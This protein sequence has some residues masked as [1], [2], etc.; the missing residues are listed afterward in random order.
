MA[1]LN[2]PDTTGYLLKLLSPA[3]FICFGQVNKQTNHL[4][5]NS[6][7]YQELCRLKFDKKV[8]KFGSYQIIKRYYAHDM[9]NVIAHYHFDCYHA[10][11]LAAKHGYLN[12]LRFIHETTR[13]HFPLAHYGLQNKNLI[14]NAIDIAIA[15]KHFHILKWFEHTGIITNH[16]LFLLSDIEYAATIGDLSMLQYLQQNIALF[17]SYW[18]VIVACAIEH[19]HIVIL[20]W[21]L[22]ITEDN[23]NYH[24]NQHSVDIKIPKPDP[25]DHDKKR[26]MSVL[27]WLGDNGK[28]FPNKL[29]LR[30]RNVCLHGS[31]DLCIKIHTQFELS[32]T[33]FTDYVYIGNLDM[34]QWLYDNYRIHFT[35]LLKEIIGSAVIYDHLHILQWLKS[36]FTD[37]PTRLQLMTDINFVATAIRNGSIGMLELLDANGVI[38]NRS[39][40][41]YS[42]QHTARKGYIHVLAWLKSRGLLDANSIITLAIQ[43]AIEGGHT[44][45]LTWL[46]KNTVDHL[47]NDAVQLAIQSNQIEVLELF[48]QWH[49]DMPRHN[50]A[51]LFK[52]GQYR[53]AHDFYSL[54]CWLKEH[55]PKFN[56]HTM[57]HRA[58]KYDEWHVVQWILQYYHPALRC[59]CRDIRT[60]IEHYQ[61]FLRDHN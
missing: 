41:W 26:L 1:L 35:I 59:L 24:D 19:G 8:H 39:A 45:I 27:N 40:L 42:I 51:K 23:F 3:E 38:I 53:L 25:S 10:I 5:R 17:P 54:I 60:K 52:L 34:L 13:L 32:D 11:T 48:H 46:G 12:L 37:I 36:I 50:L 9:I 43:G 7:I 15:H 58:V 2:N 30:Y 4:V 16:G 14:E 31:L 28:K 56:L 6:L 61:T 22:A 20:D 55:N 33:V 47:A 44:H 29:N 49:Y 18:P 21:I 57:L